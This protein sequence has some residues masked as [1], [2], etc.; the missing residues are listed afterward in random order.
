VVVCC[1]LEKEKS[2]TGATRGLIPKHVKEAERTNKASQGM[3]VFLPKGFLISESNILAPALFYFCV[4]FCVVTKYVT[5][6]SG[7]ASIYYP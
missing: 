5:V 4:F 3:L 7:K 1:G 2:D 6:L